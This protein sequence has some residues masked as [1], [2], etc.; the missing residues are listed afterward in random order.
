MSNCVGSS[1]GKGGTRSNLERARVAD[2]ANLAA[3]RA[4][5][6]QWEAGKPPE[7]LQRT[8]TESCIRRCGD[9]ADR[10]Q[11]DHLLERETV[12]P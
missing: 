6:E 5:L 7:G 12:A 3:A 8:L 9:L 10:A 11:L 1:G 2:R 4:T